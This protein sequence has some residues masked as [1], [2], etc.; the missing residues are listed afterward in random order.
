M[1]ELKLLLQIIPD[2]DKIGHLFIVDI[3]FDEVNADEKKSCCL[4][5]I[6]LQFFGKKGIISLDVRSVF[7][8]LH[9]V[10]LNNKGTLNPLSANPTK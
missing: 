5:K 9:A 3:E 8:L 2:K 10:R 4:M 1:R 7:Q 6:I